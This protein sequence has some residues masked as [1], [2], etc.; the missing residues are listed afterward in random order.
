[1]DI[2]LINSDANETSLK[3]M[4]ADIGALYI[5]QHELIKDKNTEFAGVIIKHPLTNEIWMRVSSKLNTMSQ[6]SAATDTAIAE[7]AS[8]QKLINLKI[9]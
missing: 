8:L 5:I 6:I 2:Q 1:L 9:K 3:I 4:D 7:V